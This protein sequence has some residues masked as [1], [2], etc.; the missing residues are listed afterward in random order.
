[1][2]RAAVLWTGGKDSCLALL[3]VRERYEVTRLVTFTADPPRPFLAHPLPLL[4]AQADA[5]GLEHEVVPLR[6]P[7]AEAYE[8]AFDRLASDGTDV[9]VTG[10]M[11]RVGGH[12]NWV[13][14]RARGR[15]GVEQPLWQADRIAVLGELQRLRLDVVCTLEKREVFDAPIVGRRFDTEL[16][17]ELCR[18]H[19]SEGFDAC[20]ENGEYH[21]CVLM[22]PGF[23]HP[24]RL[25][26]ARIL[27]AG[28]YRHLAFDGVTPRKRM[29]PGRE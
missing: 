5:L 1:M 8:A 15:I 22:A 12:D 4:A 3:A 27:D 10:D 19:G 24:L 2:E 26:G 29:S 18:R 7:L 20:G 23:R 28:P 21:T 6:E 14:E 16:V 25:E 11:D 13:V 17:A 9:V